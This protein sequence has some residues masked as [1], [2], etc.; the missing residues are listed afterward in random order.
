MREE[1]KEGLGFKGGS[2]LPKRWE[3][4]EIRKILTTIRI[5]CNKKS[6]KAGTP[7]YT[8]YSKGKQE[9]K[10]FRPTGPS[11]PLFLKK[12]RFAVILFTYHDSV[13]NSMKEMFSVE[14]RS[15]FTLHTQM[16]LLG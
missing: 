3:L 14:P 1:E 10:S 11:P 13:L 8:G 12:K 7:Y 16:T 2:D 9:A 6:T 5:F 15:R 4:K